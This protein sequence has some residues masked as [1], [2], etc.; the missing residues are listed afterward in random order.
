LWYLM[1]SRIFDIFPTVPCT[2]SSEIELNNTDR[3]IFILIKVKKY[4]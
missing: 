2:C 4:S 3:N 1:N